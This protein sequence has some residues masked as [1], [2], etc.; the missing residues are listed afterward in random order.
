MSDKRF[1]YLV[2]DQARRQAAEY[3]FLAPEGHRVTFSEPDKSRLQEEKY[4][5]M[6]G[7]IAQQCTFMGQKWDKDDWKRLL[8]D[9]FAKAMKEAGTPLTHGGQII[10]SLDG[11]G[12]VQLGH[13]SRKF[14]RREASDFIEYLYAWGADK[15]VAW[16]DPETAM[17]ALADGPPRRERAEV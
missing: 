9:A 7:D 5:A 6:V 10:P 1:F 2:H 4:H 13:Q 15:E 14:R 8:I 12:I 16:S 17:M 11:G 3:C